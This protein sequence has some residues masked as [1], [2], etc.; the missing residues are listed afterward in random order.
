LLQFSSHAWVR[1]VALGLM[2]T[3]LAMV[4][5]VAGAILLWVPDQIRSVQVHLAAAV[6]LVIAV[7][8][9]TWGEGTMVSGSATTRWLARL[10]ALA[11]LLPWV[12]LAVIILRNRDPDA[13]LQFRRTIKL[14]VIV[15]LAIQA[16]LAV[17][18]GFYATHLAIRVPSD[19]LAIQSKTTGWL[20]GVV[21]LVLLGIQ[22]FDMTERTYYMMFMC[23]F[24]MVVGLLVILAWG[25]ITLMRL[26]FDMRQA[27][28]AGE[29]ITVRRMERIAA[30]KRPP[31]GRDEG[32]DV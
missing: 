22:F 28:T 31:P 23:S 30:K 26:G 21:C 1:T 24:P 4:G 6:L 18:M 5:H 15:E 17:V 25:M 11:A 8:V 9:A 10:A 2:L 7:F 16:F 29:L 12:A 32:I 27:A 14:L 20:A 13:L 3:A 19:T